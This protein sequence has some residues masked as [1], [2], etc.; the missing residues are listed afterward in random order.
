METFASDHRWYACSP[1]EKR[2][3]SLG[4][5]RSRC[6]CKNLQSPSG[7]REPAPWQGSPSCS[8]SR[9][10]RV[11]A[12]RED[13]CRV[14]QRQDR[15]WRSNRVAWRK[16]QAPSTARRFL[17]TPTSCW[18]WP[19]CSSANHFEARPPVPSTSRSCAGSWNNQQRGERRL[20]AQV[21]D[22]GV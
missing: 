21:K 9:R 16:T 3:V 8:L 22:E 5:T 7:A 11:V 19:P 4:L 2:D 10:A 6:P 14:P 17:G 15:R 20:H 12:T 1:M 13:P 18:A